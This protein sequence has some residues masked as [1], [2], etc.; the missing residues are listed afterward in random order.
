MADTHTPAS[1]IEFIAKAIVNNPD[2]V[3]V[4]EVDDGRLLELET[5]AEDRGRV[6]GR[7]GRVAK[8]LRAVLE[9][10]RDGADCRLDIVD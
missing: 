4:T 5:D 8:A 1:L 3:A 10:S 7:Q 2:S 9:A 6:I